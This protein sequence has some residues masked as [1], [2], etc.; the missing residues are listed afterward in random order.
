MH[1]TIQWPTA[2][3]GG[4]ASSSITT[5]QYVS[6][7]CHDVWIIPMMFIWLPPTYE[8][9]GKMVK[10]PWLVST[11]QIFYVNANDAFFKR[12]KSAGA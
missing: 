12:R 6:I 7:D 10:Q 4:P 1:N 9:N 5:S 3:V 2:G 11:I 8:T